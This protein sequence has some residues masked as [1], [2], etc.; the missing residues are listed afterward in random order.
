MGCFVSCFRS[1]D[2]DRKIQ[3]RTRARSN[4]DSYFDMVRFSSISL[5]ICAYFLNSKDVIFLDISM[6]ESLEE[7]LVVE[8][9]SVTGSLFLNGENGAIFFL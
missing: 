7:R 9:Q 8:N 6:Q 4:S 5:L 2:R 3:S 1:K